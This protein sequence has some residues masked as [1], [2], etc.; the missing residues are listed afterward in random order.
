MDGLDEIL[1]AGGPCDLQITGER[2]II[3]MLACD[4]LDLA[5]VAVSEGEPEDVVCLEVGRC[6]GMVDLLG[7]EGR[8]RFWRH[9]ALKFQRTGYDWRRLP[10][11]CDYLDAASR[12]QG[13]DAMTASLMLRLG[14]RIFRRGEETGIPFEGN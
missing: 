6:V 2:D 11:L 5:M 12:E 13:V 4:Y 8:A 3:T 9:M 14:E 10:V 1:C 7:R